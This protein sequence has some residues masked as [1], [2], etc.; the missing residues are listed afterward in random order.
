MAVAVTVAEYVPAVSPVVSTARDIAFCGV[1][2]DTGVTVN[3]GASSVTEKFATEPLLEFRLTMLF[4]GLVP[5]DVVKL[6]LAGL[7]I[8]AV[9]V[10]LLLKEELITSVPPALNPYLTHTINIH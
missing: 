3:Q 5:V 6:T 8:N 9:D 7:K 1:V 2:P 4:A 10:L